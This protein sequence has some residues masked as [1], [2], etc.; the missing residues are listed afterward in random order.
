MRVLVCLVVTFV[1][2][3]AMSG[4]G[5][6][7]KEQAGAPQRPSVI[8]AIEGDIDSFNP[9][10]AEDITAGEI[11][12]LLFPSL[13]GS[14]FDLRSGELAYAPLLARSWERAN[15]DRDIVFHLLP[16]ARWTDGSPVTAKDVQLTFE[17]YGDPDVASVRQAS[18]ENLERRDGHIDISKSVEV[19]DD[20]T[21]VFHFARAYPGQLFDAGLPILPAHI[22]EK[23][24]RKDLRTDPANRSPVGFGPFSLARWTPL[25]EVVLQSNPE[26]VVP[27]PAKLSRLLVRVIPDYRMRISQLESGEVDLVTG[28]RPEDAD[29]LARDAPGIDIVSTPGR[30]Y[31]FLGWN[32]IEPP[33]KAG[34]PGAA[35]RPHRLFGSRNARRALTMAIDRDELVHAYLGKHGQ[36]AFGGISPLFRWAYNDTLKPLPFDPHQASALLE[37]EGWKDTDGDGI[38]DRHGVRFSFILKVPA[39]NQLRTVVATAVQQQLKQIKIEVRIEQV[40]RA[41]FWQ[42]VTARKY[43]AWLAGFSVPLQ[44]KMDDLWGSDLEKYPFNLTG[45]RNTRVDRILASART[46]K[47]ER[48]G[49]SL[50]KEFQTIVHEE[51]PCTFLYWINSIVAVNK[52]V[53]GTGIGVLGTLH[54]AW[55]WHVDSAGTGDATPSR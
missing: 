28:L 46:L 40:E 14:S 50:W 1:L 22:F 17:L 23:L 9:L 21:V 36:V 29:R 43:D 31:D 33:S 30:D 42:D 48:E 19:R 2:S 20:S 38:L 8:I 51:Q 41:T 55:E 45:F 53:R 26:S 27:Y 37:Q 7:N 32:N 49:A 3:V 10:F 52:R 39:G 44:M 47:A 16:N 35:N 24:P 15:H 13:V 12:D 4:C 34:R 18:V 5:T 6:R 54:Q 25:Q 11:N